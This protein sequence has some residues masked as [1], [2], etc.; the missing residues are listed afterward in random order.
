MSNNAA[1]AEAQ[2]A[3]DALNATPSAKSTGTALSVVGNANATVPVPTTYNQMLEMSQLMARGGPM[4][5]KAF[6]SQ[7]GACLAILQQALRL[8][9][10][11]YMMSQKAYLVGETIGYE[12]QLVAAI[13]YKNAPIQGRLR[14]T[15]DGQGDTRT[16][17]ITG[18]IEGEAQ[19]CDYTSP[20]LKTLKGHSPL[21]VKDPDQQ[22]YYYAVRA[23]ARRWLPEVIMGVYTPDE[24][25]DGLV[26][27]RAAQTGESMS[28]IAEEGHV[29]DAD[30]TPIDTLLNKSGGQSNDQAAAKVQAEG[31]GGA[32]PGGENA[33]G[34]KSKGKAAK[35]AAG[36]AAPASGAGGE[37]AAAPKDDGS[38]TQQAAEVGKSSAAEQDG[39]DD[40]AADREDADLV[41]RV[42]AEV[43]AANPTERSQP[44]RAARG[45]LE[46]IAQTHADAA[47]KSRAAKLL[48]MFDLD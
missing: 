37:A 40:G 48:N 45:A 35:Q 13:I 7:P 18:M 28:L 33:K 11:P 15:Y 26:D 14:P 20:P 32:A 25:Q 41:G 6:R 46:R 31:D 4:V 19:P 21:W 39:A 43:K 12:A 34:S 47:V 9:F 3:D 17:T 29:T 23:W 5:G 10:D 24:V 38:T 16:V 42:E 30:F 2:R 27:D 1:T 8:G 44:I 36:S 22:L